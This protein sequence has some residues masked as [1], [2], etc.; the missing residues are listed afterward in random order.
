[1]TQ[2]AGGEDA[3]VVDDEQIAGPQ[4]RRQIGDRPV[5]HGAGGPIERHQTRL[6]AWQRGLGDEVVGQREVEVSDEHG[7]LAAGTIRAL[8]PPAWKSLSR[9]TAK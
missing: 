1:M 5:R 6:A 2:Q 9:P 7:T 3:G 8:H 4:Q